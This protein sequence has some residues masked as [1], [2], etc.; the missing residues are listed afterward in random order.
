MEMCNWKYKLTSTRIVKN[1]SSSSRVLAAALPVRF[2]SGTSEG[3]KLPD[4]GSPGERASEME[5]M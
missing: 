3:R 5:V 1:Y 4:P 2:F